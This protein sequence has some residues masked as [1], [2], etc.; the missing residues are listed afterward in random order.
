[1][2]RPPLFRLIPLFIAFSCVSCGDDPQ[3]VA[4]REKQKAEI[5]RLKGEIVLIEEKLKNVPPDVSEELKAAKKQEEEQA[6]E[7][8]KLESEVSALE[9]RKRSLQSEFDSYRAKYQVK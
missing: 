3:M 4:K 6:A 2:K 7:I 9:A 1:M 8:A 5:A